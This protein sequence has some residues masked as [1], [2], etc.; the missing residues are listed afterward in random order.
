MIFF[1]FILFSQEIKRIRVK[2][3]PLLSLIPLSCIVASKRDLE[4]IHFSTLAPIFTTLHIAYIPASEM[5][6]MDNFNN[7]RGIL[8][9]SSKASSRSTSISSSISSQSYH[10][11]IVINNNLSNKNLRE[12][13]NSSQLSYKDNSEE[14]GLVSKA[15]DYGSTRD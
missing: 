3:D 12:P 11:R 4:N 1:P 6:D 2:C 14:R 10:E 5:I 9:S 15:T 7:I 13:I 8:H